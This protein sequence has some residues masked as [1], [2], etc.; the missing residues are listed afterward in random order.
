MLEECDLLGSGVVNDWETRLSAH[1]A[2]QIRAG[3]MRWFVAESGGGIVGTAAAILQQRAGDIWL[4]KV[5]T[6]AGIYVLPA[7]RRNGIARELTQRAIAWCKAQECRLIKLQA[8][9][10]GRPLY[11]SLGFTAGTEMQLP[12]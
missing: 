11:E 12:V 7:F 6:L 4:D 8:S 1:F 9:K 5:A 2:S 3:H 10:A